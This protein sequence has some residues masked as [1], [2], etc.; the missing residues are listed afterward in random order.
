MK[1]ANVLGSLFFIGACSFAYGF[2]GFLIALGILVPLW[3][4]A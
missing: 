1:V 3:D 4:N 2:A